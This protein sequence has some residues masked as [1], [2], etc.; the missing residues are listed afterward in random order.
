[1]GL[2]K[3]LIYKYLFQLLEDIALQDVHA[4]IAVDRAGLVPGDGVTHQG[5]FDVALM[6]TI[7]GITL[8]SP[9]TFEETEDCLEKCLQG[10]GLCAVRYP[11]GDEA[12]YDRSGFLAVGDG[13]LATGD[14]G[15]DIV[16][17]SYS[18]VTKEAYKAK[19]IL[20]EKY[21]T[22]C[23]KLVNVMYYLAFLMHMVAVVS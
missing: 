6:S 13:I 21:N 3:Y 7:P 14:D 9:E 12:R 5:V 11:K 17:I 2:L 4:V 18:R 22:K 23:V 15:A 20:S 1:M 8:Y 10:K 19:E 16:I